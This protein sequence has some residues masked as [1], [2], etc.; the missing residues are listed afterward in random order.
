MDFATESKGYQWK[1]QLHI[2][3][4]NTTYKQGG[5]KVFQFRIWRKGRST[6]GWRISNKRAPWH[7]NYN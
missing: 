7:N 5:N 3:I 6:M 1:I 4:D 2:S